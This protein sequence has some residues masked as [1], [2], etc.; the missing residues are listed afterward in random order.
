MKKVTK[1][2]LALLSG[3]LLAAAWPTKGFTALIFI[4]FVPLI[5]LQDNISN[6]KKNGIFGLSFL[7][8]LVWNSLTTWWVWNSTAA[9]AVAMLLLNSTFMATTFWLYHFTRKNVF[10][11][12]KGYFLLVIFFL[13]FENLH[14]NWQL[15][16]PWLNIGNVFS[17]KH[18]WVQWYEITGISGGTIWVLLVNILLY[19]L[20]KAVIEKE[21]QTLKRYAVFAAVALILPI[22]ISKIM[23]LTYED[24]GED[25][26]VVV[27]QPNI[28]PYKEEYVLSAAEILKRNFE[29]AELLVTEN[30][31]FVVGPESSIHESIWLESINSYY[32][33]RNLRLF[34]KNNAGLAYVIGASTLGMVPEGEE[35]DFAARKFFDAEEYYYSYNTALMVSDNEKIQYHQKSKLT[36]G[37]EMMP[38]WWILRPIKNLAIDLGGTV[39]TLKR[40][41]KLTLLEFEDHKVAPMICYES[42]FGDYVSKF[43]REGAD[44]IFVITNDGWWGDTPGH[45]QHFEMSKLRAIENRRCVARSANTGISCFINQRGDVLESTNYWQP[46]VL[47]NTMKANEELTFYSKYGDNLYRVG[48]LVALLLICFSIVITVSKRER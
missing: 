46:A 14:L 12:K 1:I 41:N 33:I 8:F 7:S 6:N 18:T 47:V 27:V 2:S 44:L 22:T 32:S 19:Q 20:L 4:A 34:S 29:L 9:G 39:G 11:N 43:V 15:N 26:E 45:R 42:V 37:V 10:K 48:S 23:Y 16:W 35:K 40:E 17:H 5:Y 21:K 38:S 3:L 13:A 31:R 30:T 24:K 25:V 28:D 36:P